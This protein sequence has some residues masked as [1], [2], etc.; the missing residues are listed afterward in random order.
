MLVGA[1]AA[2][3]G[4]Y[5]SGSLFAG[6][7]AAM[8]AATALAA[9]HGL[10]VL[11]FKANLFISGLAINLLASG[12]TAALSSGLFGVRG[13]FA[14]AAVASGAGLSQTGSI[15]GLSFSF[16]LGLFVAFQAWVCLYRTPFGFRLRACGDGGKGSGDGAASL[17]ALGMKPERYRMASF[18]I[19]G[20]LCGIA[21]SALSLGVGAFVPDM[22]S[23][24]GWVA[25][26]L[27]Y[28]GRRRPGGLC[29]A[30]LIFGF[31]DA[32]SNYAQG[33]FN[34]PADFILAIP[35]VLSLIALVAAAKGKRPGGIM[36]A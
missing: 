10:A 32:F 34:L 5:Y 19:C 33:V 35:Y 6:L 9:L 23:G 21:G 36:E 22:T 31:A 4:V 15:F 2:L 8:L 25:L 3:A 14:P 13:V 17:S 20:A 12:L 1:F 28:L 24:R 18:I 30:A 16:W 29:I 11:R 26:A 7:I 27:I